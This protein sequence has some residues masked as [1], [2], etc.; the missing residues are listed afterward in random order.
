MESEGYGRLDE[1]M[2]SLDDSDLRLLLVAKAQDYRPEALEIARAELARR[3]LPMLSPKE[4]WHQ[5]P[6]EWLKGL[7]FCYR[8]WAETTDESPEGSFTVDLI[9]TRLI[10]ADSE[11]PT[12]HSAITTS[13]FCVVVPVRRLGRYRVLPGGPKGRRLKEDHA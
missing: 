9:G 10:G 11:C 13:W 12:C 1:R 4:Y 7:G 3:R 5:F 2:R 8:C 6:D